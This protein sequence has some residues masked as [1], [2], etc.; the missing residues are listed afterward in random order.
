MVSRGKALIESASRFGLFAG[1]CGLIVLLVLL[2]VGTSCYDFSTCLYSAEREGSFAAAER[3]YLTAGTES[4]K[5]VE[6]GAI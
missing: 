3:P 1:H 2:D 5:V 6:K 4:S